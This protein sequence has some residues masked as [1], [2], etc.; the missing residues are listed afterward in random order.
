MLLFLCFCS[1]ILQA[2][3]LGCVCEPN[4]SCLNEEGQPVDWFIMYKLPK[5]KKSEVGSGVEYMYLDP[6]MLNWQMSPFAVNTSE[7]AVGRTLSQL[8]HR[9]KS[10]S[11]AY[12]LYNDAPPVL[13][14]QNNYG[15]TKGTLLFNQFQG[16][17]IIHSVPHFPPFPEMGFGYPSTGKLFGQTV[18]C[19]TYSYTQFKKISQQ[20]AYV[21]PRAYNCSLPAAYHTD[22]PAMAQICGG[23]TPTVVPRRKLEKLESVQ[24]QTFLSF[25]KSHS[26]VDDI[27]AGWV[28]QTLRT[29]LL[30]ES[31]QRDNHQLPSNCSL[32]YHVLNIKRVCLPG[33]I[34]FSS[35]E[36][37]S[38]WCVSLEFGAQWTCV[39]DLNRESAQAFRGG[40]LI[41]SQNPAVYKAFHQA[42]DWFQ[43][44]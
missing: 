38:K 6:S 17:W 12:M 23:K 44:C 16:F 2:F 30:V 7:G 29:D 4:I 10:N 3:P 9:Y 8:Y 39:G 15:H 28:A 25:V 31:W 11:S 14:Y 13:K 33:N 5:Y 41:C 35:Y 20:L 34:V 19:T 32:P 21:N 1:I 37:H 43:S 22:M 27:Y 18:H 36:D 40:G 24:G 26:Y 42:V